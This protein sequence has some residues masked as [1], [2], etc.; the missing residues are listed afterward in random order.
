MRVSGQKACCPAWGSLGDKI[1]TEGMLGLVMTR[2][3]VRKNVKF[4]LQI[5][6]GM[7][8][9]KRSWTVKH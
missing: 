5:R 8:K 4:D 6:G 3:K 2:F 7:F 9:Y 1:P